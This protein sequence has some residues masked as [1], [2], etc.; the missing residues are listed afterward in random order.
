[1]PSVSSPEVN[2]AHLARQV[3]M[4]L[5]LAGDVLHILPEGF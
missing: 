4:G 5:Q 3:G 2:Y 1:M